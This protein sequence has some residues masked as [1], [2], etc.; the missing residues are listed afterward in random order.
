MSLSKQSDDG[1]L[2]FAVHAA[3]ERN[4]CPQK[5]GLLSFLLRA[6]IESHCSSHLMRRPPLPPYS[7]CPRHHDA[8][9]AQTKLGKRQTAGVVYD[10]WHS[11]IA[12]HTATEAIT[13]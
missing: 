5:G 7:Y 4:H 11:I 8:S 1:H 12:V 9:S 6:D 10:G 3:F 2:A 13:L